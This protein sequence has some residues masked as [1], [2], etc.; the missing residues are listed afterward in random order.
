[1]ISFGTTRTAVDVAYEVFR[2]RAVR[3]GPSSLDPSA[4]ARNAA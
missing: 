4:D 1:M 3:S 2:I